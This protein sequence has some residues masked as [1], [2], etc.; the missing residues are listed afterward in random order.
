MFLTA[1]AKA[2]Q[3]NATLK[4]DLT[5]LKQSDIG[6]SEYRRNNS[7]EK[8]MLF[9]MS[10]TIECQAREK[11]PV[12]VTVGTIVEQPSRGNTVAVSWSYRPILAP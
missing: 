2:V 4:L 8:L 12:T 9:L 5:A 7:E 3:D 11:A 1:D 10:A 6:L